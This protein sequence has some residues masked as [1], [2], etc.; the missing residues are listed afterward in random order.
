MT[1]FRLLC[2]IGAFTTTAVAST[3][4]AA[5]TWE[6]KDAA[7]IAL[8]A[9]CA[10]SRTSSGKDGYVEPE[11]NKDVQN[12]RKSSYDLRGKL[13]TL[14]DKLDFSSGYPEFPAAYTSVF[15]VLALPGIIFAILGV[16]CCFPCWCGKTCGEIT[17]CC[18]GGKGCFGGC[19]DYFL[20][21]TPCPF[22]TGAC[23]WGPV[24]DYGTFF[25]FSKFERNP[26]LQGDEKSGCLCCAGKLIELGE[27]ES[28]H[29]RDDYFSE[30]KKPMERRC[31]I[32]NIV[33]LIFIVLS[34]VLICAFA[35]W[36]SVQLDLMMNGIADAIDEASCV[37]E[38]SIML[39]QDIQKPLMNISKIGGDASA[40]MKVV[41]TNAGD[42]DEVF[43][44]IGAD[45]TTLAATIKSDPCN[46]LATGFSTAETT[47]SE[48]A[49][50]A[51]YPSVE[52]LSAS[53]LVET[54][55]QELTNAK[56]G[57]ESMVSSLDT[58][59]TVADALNTTIKTAVAAASKALGGP[60]VDLLIGSVRPINS[61]VGKYLGDVKEYQGHT[62][63]ALYVLIF[64]VVI[65]IVFVSI[66]WLVLTEL[67]ECCQK[68]G[69]K[70]INA[71]LNGDVEMVDVEGDV[72]GG[73][74]EASGES[75]DD[76]D[77]D[78][79]SVAQPIDE[80]IEVKAVGTCGDCLCTMFQLTSIWSMH[81]L[82]TIG[83][84]IMMLTFI[85]AAFFSPLTVLVSDSCT[86]I[87]HVASNPQ[88]WLNSPSSP[89]KNET[90]VLNLVG[91][92]LDVNDGN[93][94]KALGVDKQLDI[95]SM[96][97]TSNGT[98]LDVGGLLT[99]GS[100]SVMTSTI[101]GL[102]NRE[103]GWGS[104]SPPGPIG[105]ELGLLSSEMGTTYT[106]DDCN[107]PAPDNN[108]QCAPGA[109]G[110]AATKRDDVMSMIDVYTCTAN[111]IQS[112]QTEAARI[113][114]ALSTF[115][116]RMSSVQVDLSAVV[117]SATEP[118]QDNINHMIALGSCSFLRK[119]LNGGL[120]SVCGDFLQGL[121]NM[122]VNLTLIA[123]TFLFMLMI[124]SNCA[125][126]R[127]R[128]YDVA[129]WRHSATRGCPGGSKEDSA[130][131][132]PERFEYDN[133]GNAKPVYD[134]DDDDKED[135]KL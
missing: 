65:A 120:T 56:G 80:E 4:T 93:M 73:D 50:G 55:G 75:D 70:K 53:T 68:A 128:M 33:W 100:L 23:R 36:G 113:D 133:D 83:W 45:L 42:L 61:K 90:L 17:A 72:V 6:K 52:M 51:R 121:T 129:C 101:N 66:S 108:G 3:P 84:I 18:C 16:V 92:C 116:T 28:Y 122:A 26:N 114:T 117:P 85:A 107:G 119:R 134:D 14:P 130:T 1:A 10:K 63:T 43:A 127:F 131:I 132:A 111:H 19:N 46:F 29:E 135:S 77:V 5:P 81:T 21:C 105:D 124:L 106:Y 126:Q 104:G 38:D 27:G 115:K 39:T 37:V 12:Y 89:V 20:G 25:P 32:P 15:V 97:D 103:L 60:M 11:A 69:E 8:L 48:N 78:F 88:L 109:T 99:F 95:V 44:A 102:T 22:P 87:D 86:I 98:S 76:G 40:N 35:V 47:S 7:T 96:M 67:Y 91:A 123:F 62:S 79:V 71:T 118:I 34:G 112:I 58:V 54:L 110:T 82:H 31:S 74:K 24:A 30:R 13:D 2:A 49:N 64:I 94:L 125:I 41:V 57:V 9:K 59:N